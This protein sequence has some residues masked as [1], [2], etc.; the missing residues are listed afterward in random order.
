MFC[1]SPTG[2]SKRIP[3][4]TLS[5]RIT[6]NYPPW[7]IIVSFICSKPDG[8]LTPHTT[9]NV[10]RALTYLWNFVQPIDTREVHDLPTCFFQNITQDRDGG[11]QTS[12]NEG[13]YI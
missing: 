12:E 1:K 5:E 3:P 10:I 11:E 8:T 6:N 7:T 13:Y 2:I 9:G 4:S